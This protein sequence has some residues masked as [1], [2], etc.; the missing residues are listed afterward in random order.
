VRAKTAAEARNVR[1]DRYGADSKMCAGRFLLADSCSVDRIIQ[2][3]AG[4]RDWA[5]HQLAHL[6]SPALIQCALVKRRPWSTVWQIEVAGR[7][8]YLKAAAPGYDV[9]PKLLERLCK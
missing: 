7:R 2:M 3:D 1:D 9:E 6:Q 5:R 4:Y 8:Y